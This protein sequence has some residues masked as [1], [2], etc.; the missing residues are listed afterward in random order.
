MGVS[1]DF[2]LK[3]PR[4][5]KRYNSMNDLRT[6][7]ELENNFIFEYDN[8]GSATRLDNLS[9]SLSSIKPWMKEG[10]GIFLLDQYYSIS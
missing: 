5:C 7:V 8:F 4:V 2:D 10:T 1:S 6:E 9:L 3:Y